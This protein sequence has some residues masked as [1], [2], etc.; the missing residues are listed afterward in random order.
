MCWG[1]QIDIPANG[2]A[3]GIDDVRGFSGRIA[4]ANRDIPVL[5][6]RD[7]ERE[8]ITTTFGV[9]VNSHGSFKRFWNARKEALHTAHCW[10]G[11]LG[12]HAI[13]P[14]TAYVENSPHETWHLGERAWIPALIKAGHGAGIA[15]I[16]DENQSPIL[17]DQE[18][19]IAW[20]NTARW[21]VMEALNKMP[22]QC[23][24]EADIFMHARLKAD[25]RSR[26]PIQR[27]VHAV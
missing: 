12:Q 11:L 2:K 20:L 4:T 17:T 1:L 7:G 3:N 24:D 5:V 13:I 19:A 27:N 10:T 22:R 21:N 8:W 26:A 6:G 14:V 16:T 18:H 15:V 23:F 25:A 9:G